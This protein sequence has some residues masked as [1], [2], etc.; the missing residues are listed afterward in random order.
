MKKLKEKIKKNRKKIVIGLGMIGGGVILYKLGVKSGYKKLY[1][2]RHD[3]FVQPIKGEIIEWFDDEILADNKIIEEV[4]WATANTG[5]L[6]ELPKE[7]RDILKEADEGVENFE[8]F[9]RI[10]IARVSD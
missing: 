2:N 5:K 9:N 4:F 3:Q 8:N 6:V 1:T 10:L 7:F